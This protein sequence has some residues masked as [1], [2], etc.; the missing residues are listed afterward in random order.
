M[1]PLD[2]IRRRGSA[3]LDA[4]PD[5]PDAVPSEDVESALRKQAACSKCG[6]E[7]TRVVTATGETRRHCTCGYNWPVALSVPSESIPATISR[8][9]GKQ[10][11][12]DQM[13][14]TTLSEQPTFSASVPTDKKTR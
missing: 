3:E 8:G 12:V 9:F 1:E 5:L 11:F 6:N 13:D 7:N 2:Q 10:T 4:P 14:L